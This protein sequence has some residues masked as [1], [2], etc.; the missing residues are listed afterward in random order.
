MPQVWL[1]ALAQ[2]FAQAGTIIFITYG[3]ILGTE[4]APSAGMATLPLALFVAGVALTSLPAALMMQRVGRRRVFMGS[5]CFAA[6]TALLC[7]YSV[8]AQ[9][10]GGFCAAAFLFGTNNAVVQQYRFAAADFVSSGHTARAVSTVMLGTL[11]AAFLWPEVGDRMRLA[12]GWSEFTGSFLAV[13]VLCLLAVAVLSRLP[14][15]TVEKRERQIAARPVGEILRNPVCLVAIFAGVCSYAAMSFIM[16]ATPISMHMIDALSVAHTKRV[17]STHLIAMYLP[18][19][20]S[21]WL[22]RW[23]GILRMMSLGV[24]CMLACV[25][26]SAFV[27]HQ[28]VHYLVALALL[29]AGWNLLFVGGTTLLTSSYAPSDRFRAQGINDL[30][31]FG[32]QALVSLLAG[33]AI[34]HLHWQTLNLLTVPLL[35]LMVAAIGWLLWQRRAASRYRPQ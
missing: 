1:L 35:L 25:I 8:S 24:A 2:A 26:V 34:V 28:F 19:L 12:G 22:I 21:G 29:G 11:T 18:S 7:A 32:T 14:A 9:H 27:G 15:M 5:A 23:L 16:T 3:G 33:P 10:Y 31:V 13:A 30:A 17:I 6:C 4:L 20:F